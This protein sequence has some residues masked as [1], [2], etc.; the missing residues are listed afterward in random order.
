MVP[1]NL[2][3]ISFILP[4]LRGHVEP[5]NALGRCL[6]QRGHRVSMCLDRDSGDLVHPDLEHIPLDLPLGRQQFEQTMSLATQPHH[7][8][9][10]IQTMA[11]RTD[12]LCA[13]LPNIFRAHSIDVV[14][15]DQT[16]A[17]GALVA[18]AL[19]KIDISF[20][21]ALPLNR[22]DSVPPAYVG[23]RYG[24]G[25]WRKTLNR[26]GYRVAD[27]LM[28]PLS[29]TIRRNARQFGLDGVG[30]LEDCFSERLQLFQCPAGFDFPRSRLSPAAHYVGPLRLEKPEKFAVHSD[31][32]PIAFCSLGTVQGWRFSIFEA[33][34]ATAERL[35][36]QLMIAHNGKL[37]PDQI[38]QLS[39]RAIVYDFVPQLQLLRQASLAILHAGLNSTL[40]ALSCG[41]PVVAIPLAFEQAAIAARLE[42]SGAGLIVERYLVRA[43]LTKACEAALNSSSLR[44]SAKRLAQQ[45]A[46]AGGVNRAADLVEQAL[47]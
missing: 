37:N 22:D 39:S 43:K 6:L 30:K 41:V 17:A 5:A 15:S 23:W 44:T 16:E 9:A 26:G 10:T 25:P 28:L 21:A 19:S 7:L 11:S 47:A 4:P 8:L 29:R 36:L 45:I 13:V 34:A 3:H 20:A 40:D 42:R 32:R 12:T 24:T 46:D 27:W 18:R 35:G 2:A 38:T 1:K 31:G 14:I 33:A